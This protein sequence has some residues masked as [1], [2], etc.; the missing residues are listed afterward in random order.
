MLNLTNFRCA[1]SLWRR[2]ATLALVLGCAVGAMPAG[3]TFTA[4]AANAAATPSGAVP[5]LVQLPGHVNG[6]ARPQFDLGPA[7]DSLAVHGLEIVLA[8]TPAQQQ[9]IEALIAAQ[10][11]PRSTLYHRWLTPA[12]YGARFGASAATVAAMT[13]W[14]EA[15]GFSVDALP[16]N[17]SE[18]RFHGTKAQVEAAFHL[19][20]D[21]FEVAGV[22]HYA[23][24]SN[25][26]VPAGLAPA[27]AT[28]HGLND[29][30]PRST[31]RQRSAHG[32][33]AR[34]QITYDAGAESFI[35]P[36]D[37][38][39]M[40]NVG[41]LYSAG[42]NGSGVTIAVPEESDIDPTV[43]D[44]FWSDLGIAVPATI[45][46]RTVPGG[47]DPGQTMD[48]NESEAY[49]DVEV[50]G[51][52]AP[53]A[54][55]VVVSDTNAADA[56]QYIIEQ[57]LGQVVSISF[58]AC[59]SDLG[60]DNSAIDT[61]F[62]EAATQGETVLVASDDAGVAGCEQNLFTQGT[63]A[64]TGFA[65]NGLAASPHALAVGGTDFDPT[66]PQSWASSNAAGTL[67]NA[68][69]HIPEMVWN[70]TC[71][72]PLIA[73]FLSTTTS[74]LCNEAEYDGE[75]NPFLEIAGSGAGVSSCTSVDSITNACKGGYAVPSW[76][77]GVAGISG[78]SGRALPDVAVASAGWIICS[79]DDA[80]CNPANEN[81]VD[82]VGGTSSSTPAVAAIVALLDQE[83]GGG[84]GLL[85]PV[86]Y[87]LAATEYGTAAAPNA[88]AA[89]CSASLGATIGANCIFYNV[90]A[91][92]DAMPCTVASFSDAGSAPAT[93]CTA[94]GGD[95]NGIIELNGSA[96]YAAA[97]GYTIASGLGS[98]NA[99]KLVL[100]ISLPAPTGLSAK[101][102][103]QSVEL[104]WTADAHATSYDVY[105]AS[106]SGQEGT[107]AVQSGV[108]G[109]TTTVSGLKF[110]QTYYFTVAAQSAL[111]ISPQSGEIQT[112]TVPAAPTGLA[113]T[114]GN[115]QATLSWTAVSGASSYN[116]YQGTSAGGESATPVQSGISG[117][118]TTVSGLTNGTTYYFTVAAVDA[119]GASAPSNEAQASPVAPASGGGGGAMGALELA[120][121]AL[122]TSFAAASRYRPLSSELTQ[123][124]ISAR[125]IAPERR[126][127][128][129]PPRK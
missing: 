23:N 22:K 112:M 96:Q 120:L 104:S 124:A 31:L 109:A 4:A 94:A 43:A 41:P 106:T 5:G 26:Q 72:N 14:L 126:A 71:A 36:G 38:A 29:F 6:R 33:D 39:V 1:V 57:N 53:G 100:A 103:G 82:I 66:Q 93:T 2:R 65:V 30:Y 107:T 114:A 91:G 45:D 115:A 60:S 87:Q 95:A 59:E 75:P 42:I 99:A 62:S 77:S 85:N 61:L 35:A 27:I 15:G 58:S 19:E 17:R 63:L 64:T 49:L 119:G 108:S 123:R 28:I 118:S 37:F 113:A 21:L 78:L 40:Y 3:S 80:T 34:P 116:L 90:V 89:G 102:G 98:I 74:A 121:L 7:P 97:S 81:D 50:A 127:T 86:L 48:G 9:A 122:L 125:D 44:T 20:I 105:Q 54:T 117:L 101:P 11:D 47:N 111:G 76:Q 46:P 51:G 56:F 10:Q 13:R 84:Q 24:V 92:S 83:M 8:K 79:W 129:R 70:D 68:Q 32:V 128:S 88:S 18:L 73:Q 55:I 16:A 69:A 25:P 12:Q 67:A 52:I 110:A